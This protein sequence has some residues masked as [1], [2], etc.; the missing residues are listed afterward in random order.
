[1]EIVKTKKSR[2]KEVDFR[3]PGFREIFSDHM[4]SMEYKDRE[5]ESQ[6]IIPYGPME[7]CPAICSLHYAQIVFEGL[8]AFCGKNGA[9]YLFRPQKYHER[10]NQSCRRLCIPEVS[11]DVFL[12]G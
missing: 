6:R 9:V 4:L 8:K 3:K 10:M 2:L 12:E 5:W 11:L 7:I 1:M